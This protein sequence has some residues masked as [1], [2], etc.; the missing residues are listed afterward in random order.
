VRDDHAS[1]KTVKEIH[2]GGES[3]G[4]KSP[5]DAARAGQGGKKDA[6]KKDSEKKDS[7]KKDSE[8]KDSEKK[9]KGGS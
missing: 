4:Q 5:S 9:D 1:P 8:K 6:E 2:L 7:E 3:R